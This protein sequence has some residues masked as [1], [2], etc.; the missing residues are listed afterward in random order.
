MGLMLSSSSATVFV[1]AEF[2][3]NSKLLLSLDAG[4]D[5]AS[6]GWT[7]IGADW[8]GPAGFWRIAGMKDIALA[9]I[10]GVC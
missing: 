8:L 4:A 2:S 7:G 5:G 10:E 3:H 6:G 1:A 9:F